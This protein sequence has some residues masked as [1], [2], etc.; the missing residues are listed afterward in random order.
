MTKKSPS[1]EILE[2][3]LEKGANNGIFL[4]FQSIPDT[5]KYKFKLNS[6]EISP[7]TLSKADLVVL[8]T[9]HDDFDYN[10]I[11]SESK[12]IVDAEDFLLKTKM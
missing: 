12:L 4:L 2:D 5:R 11:E 3:L 7:Q 1:Q 9:D 10:L 8:A 6:V